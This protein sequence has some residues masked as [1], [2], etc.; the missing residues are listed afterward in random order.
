MKFEYNP[1]TRVRVGGSMSSAGADFVGR[2]LATAALVFSW[3]AG[4]AALI[5]AVAQLW[6]AVR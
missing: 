3:C 6:A 5:W 1:K 2:R 4:V